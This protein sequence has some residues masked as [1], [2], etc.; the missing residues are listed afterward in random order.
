MKA[1]KALKKLK[2]WLSEHFAQQDE[3]ISKKAPLFPFYDNY[4]LL[5]ESNDNKGKFFAVPGEDWYGY[6]S[7]NIEDS[8]YISKNGKKYDWIEGDNVM[9]MVPSSDAFDNAP[10][11]NRSYLR[12]TW[13][14]NNNV[15]DITNLVMDSDF[16]FLNWSDDNPWE[17][18]G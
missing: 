14:V 15:Y 18:K 1:E 13:T 5:I 2:D 11:G 10:F 4:H 7:N 12:Y 8:F 17:V 6:V 9:L 3:L 16:S